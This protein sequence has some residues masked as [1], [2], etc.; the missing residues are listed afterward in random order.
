M[1]I[2][3]KRSPKGDKKWRV[4]LSDGNIVDFGA[5]GYEDYTIHKDSDRKRNYIRRHKK[6]EK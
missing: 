2:R 6:N 4:I 3:L 5:D 1:D